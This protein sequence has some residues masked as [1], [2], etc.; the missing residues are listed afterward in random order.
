[1]ASR[2]AVDGYLAE[3]DAA[4]TGFVEG[5]YVSGSIAAR[6]L[7]AADQRR[8]PRRPL[9]RP[10]DERGASPC[11]RRFI[12]RRNRAST[13]CTQPGKTSATTPPGCRCRARSAASSTPRARSR[14]TPWCGACCRRERSQYEVLRSAPSDIWFD[15]DVL[16]HWNL[17]NLDSYWS[18]WLQWARAT[19]RDRSSSAQRVRPAVAGTRHPPPPLHRRHARR[20]VEDGWRPA[21]ARGRAAAMARRRA[22]RD[23][24]ARRP[25]S[26][27]ARATG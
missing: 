15:A 11:S 24:V 27:V 14:R 19:R 8:R 5:L 6:R 9:S 20:D 26:T 16:R 21:R 4:A 18:E 2:A 13:C 22:R 1:M 25:P 10:A 3:V 7:P 17:A 23:G 12:G